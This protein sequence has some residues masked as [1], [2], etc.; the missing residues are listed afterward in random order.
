MPTISVTPTGLW[1][2]AATAALGTVVG[3]R[4]WKLIADAPGD[5]SRGRR[6]RGN[7]YGRDDSSDEDDSDEV[8]PPPLPLPS[9]QRRRRAS[10]QRGSKK[11]LI[12]TGN[13][14]MNDDMMFA[15][16]QWGF[17]ME[18]ARAHAE[19]LAGVKNA[20]SPKEVLAELQ[21]GNA[22]FWTGA[23]TRP[24]M[25]AFERRGLIKSQFPTIAVLGCSDSRVPVEIVFDQGLGDM[26]VVRVAGNILD[27]AT[28]ASVLYAV[29]HLGV[30]VLV[31]MGHEGCGAIKASMR[32]QKD[33]DGEPEV[34]AQ[35][36]TK[37]KRN[38]DE[39]RLAW[40]QDMRARDREAVVNN[41]T[42]QVVNLTKDAEIIGK[43]NQQELI[44][45][46]AFYEISSGI[47]D[48]FYEVS[49]I[50]D[51][52]PTPKDSPL[53]DPACSPKSGPSRGVSSRFDPSTS[54]VVRERSL[55]PHLTI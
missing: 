4:L 9:H 40:A 42:Q 7:R 17:S 10:A 3:L 30:K 44:V 2:A 39:D 33:I 50:H 54:S 6:R 15:A 29:V 47:V 19:Q 28:A 8:P 45:V 1:A 41:V 37:I 32:S 12:A 21:K 22:R 13:R 36:L 14:E 31:V 55:I 18:E 25:S 34:L 23:A 51:V 38:L 48:F 52:P 35:L 5:S 20:R 53:P 43:V 49:N 46:G 26:F 11:A 24:E 16:G 27:T